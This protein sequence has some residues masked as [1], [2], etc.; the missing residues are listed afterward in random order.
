MLVISI[1]PALMSLL[2]KKTPWHSAYGILS[3]F[4]VNRAI[5]NVL[6]AFLY[7]YQPNTI[8]LSVCFYLNECIFLMLYFIKQ[9]GNSKTLFRVFLIVLIISISA[10]IFIG[11]LQDFNYLSTFLSCVFTIVSLTF[12]RELFLKYKPKILNKDPDFYFVTA[13]ILMNLPSIIIDILGSLWQDYMKSF[14]YATLL[15]RNLMSVLT[16]FFFTTGFYLLS[17]LYSRLR[18]RK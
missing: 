11:K 16:S 10:S 9:T 1:V 14:P 3:I 8:Q 6:S 15:A 17:T 2:R 5:L 18:I 12:S 4:L 13:I 7:Y